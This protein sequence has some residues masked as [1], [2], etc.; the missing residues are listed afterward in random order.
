MNGSLNKMEQLGLKLSQSNLY[1]FCDWPNKSVPQ[2]A[3]GV[4]VIYDR[5]GEFLYAGM[6]G[7]GLSKDKVKQLKEIK[8][9]K[10]GLL[11]RLGSHASGYRSGDRF[12]IYVCDLFVLKSLTSSQINDISNKRI[13]LDAINKEYIRSNLSYRYL[14]VESG[15][16]RGLERYIQE[17]GINGETPS[18]NPLV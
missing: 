5:R 10:S 15:V 16:V 13:S 9:R 17:F 4:Y 11:D 8:G 18:I 14:D 12:N 2:I 1:Y 6:A 7:A 3:A